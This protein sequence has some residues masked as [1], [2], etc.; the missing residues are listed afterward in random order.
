M[1]M[2]ELPEVEMFRR[3][4]VSTSLHKRI[5][6]IE[7]PRGSILIDATMSELREAL[8]DREI[9]SAGRHGKYLFL[10]TSNNKYLTLHFGMTGSLRYFKLPESAPSHD[11]FRISFVDGYHLSLN[12]PRLLGR[13]RLADSVERFVARHHLGPDALSI[14]YEDFR[15]TVGERRG[16]VK[17]A[18]MNQKIVAGIGNLYSDE[19]L[20]QSRIHP[21]S[22]IGKLTEQ[23]MYEMYQ[24]IRSVL[25]ASIDCRTNFACLP[26]SFLLPHRR[27]GA[28]CPGIEGR[29]AAEK[30][31]G[32]TS[33][34]CPRVQKLRS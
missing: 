26:D 31:A 10:G 1:V 30:I 12:D 34:F 13:V 4:A 23:D 32:R 19:I 15:R 8:L 3:Y 29:V 33:Y 2:P 18:L 24:C 6:E 7:A 9:I 20:F 14:T 27:K 11:R 16:M 28:E 21:K 22:Q 5:K 25:S 17:A